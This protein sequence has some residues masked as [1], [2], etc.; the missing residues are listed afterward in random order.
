MCFFLFVFHFSLVNIV[1]LISLQLVRFKCGLHDQ[2]YIL[3]SY[4][5]IY[6]AEC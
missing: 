4:S 6:T 3:F 2:L 1:S 5:M